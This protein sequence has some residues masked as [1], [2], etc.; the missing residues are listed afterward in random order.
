MGER[1]GFW[2]DVAFGSQRATT[3]LALRVGL[4]NSEL[5]LLLETDPPDPAAVPLLQQGASALIS[6]LLFPQATSPSR[7]FNDA[8]RA[9]NRAVCQVRERNPAAGDALV[10]ATAALFAE[11]SIHVASV[12]A[13]SMLLRD[14]RGTRVVVE[15]EIMAR[16]FIEEGITTVP[17][18]DPERGHAPSNGLGLPDEIFSLNQNKTLLKPNS[19]VAVICGGRMAQNVTPSHVDTISPSNRPE[20][21]AVRLYNQLAGRLSADSAIAAVQ[22][23]ATGD[24]TEIAS[25]ASR[26]FP[27]D[28]PRAVNY[29]VLLAV[30][31]LLGL[32]AAVFF[33]FSSKSDVRDRSPTRLYVPAPT[34]LLPPKESDPADAA[35]QQHLL[36]PQSTPPEWLNETDGVTREVAL[37]AGLTE[38]DARADEANARN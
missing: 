17:L 12:G 3:A 27:D 24:E 35:V 15:P 8:F 19:Y 11:N 5:V 31:A 37:P 23:L 32:A 6:S 26:R 25:G 36:S 14:E 13:N 18:P 30:I 10:S 7:V 1:M 16:K 21:I 34:L 28:R 4:Q 38:A 29:K 9:A 22:K 20:R 2:V 33:L